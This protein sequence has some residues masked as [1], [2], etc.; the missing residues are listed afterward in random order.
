[1]SGPPGEQDASTRLSEEVIYPPALIVKLSSFPL[2]HTDSRA[3][4][5]LESLVHVTGG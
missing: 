2:R 1:M 3:V 4:G 5:L